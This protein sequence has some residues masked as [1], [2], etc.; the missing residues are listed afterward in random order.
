M[1]TIGVLGGIGPQATMDF[2]TRVHAVAQQLIAPH[3]NSGYP[4]MVVYYHR[5]PPVL[6]GPDGHSPILPLQSNPTFLDAAKRIGSWADF[7]VVTANGPHMFQ[8]EIEHAAGIPML[9]MIELILVEARKRGW[10]RVG[11]LGLGEPRVHI[12]E[13]TRAGIAAEALEAELRE[14]LDAAII[15]VMEGRVGDTERAIMQEALRDLRER[16]MDGIILGCT[17]LPFLVGPADDTSPLLIN[18]IQLLAEAAVR[19]AME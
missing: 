3:A 18:P 11:A 8:A 13:L 4:P 5:E 2:E 12:E 9:S 7:L 19:R 17:E 6:V 16:D 10:R 14:R 15:K 1:K